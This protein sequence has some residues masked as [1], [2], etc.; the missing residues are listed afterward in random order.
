[1]SDLAETYASVSTKADEPC[2]FNVIALLG[3]ST[4]GE[5]GDQDVR[6]IGRLG[7]SAAM[8]RRA[9]GLADPLLI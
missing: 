7:P 1:M 6:F 9:H 8:L 3:R 5:P 4:Y 2:L